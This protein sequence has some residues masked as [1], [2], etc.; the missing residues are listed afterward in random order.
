MKE[1]EGDSKKWKETHY[2]WVRSFNILK[3]TI[4]PKQSTYLVQSLSNYP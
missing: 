4:N 2:A 1:I 3:M